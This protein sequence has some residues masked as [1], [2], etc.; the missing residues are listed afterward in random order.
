MVDDNWHFRNRSRSAIM[1]MFRAIREVQL[2]SGF[3]DSD[4]LKA[5]AAVYRETNGGFVNV[6][7]AYVILDLLRE[8]GRKSRWRDWER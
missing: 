2:V 7:L 1:A 5:M 4:I 6:A 8:E 3:K